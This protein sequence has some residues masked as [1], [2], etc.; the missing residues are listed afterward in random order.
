VSNFTVASNPRVFNRPTGEWRDGDPL[1]MRC[2][3]W[4]DAAKN[5]A[6]CLT[7]GTR[8]IAHGRL[9]QRSFET[10]QDEKRTVIELLVD[11]IGP[12]LK[13]A[14]AVVDKATRSNGEPDPTTADSDEPPF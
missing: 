9:K 1:F 8:V 3:V 2:Q 12:S 6:Q 10:R 7:R 11:E 13:W 14:T 4:R 5:V